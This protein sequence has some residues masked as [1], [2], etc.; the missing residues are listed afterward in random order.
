AS[1]AYVAEAT[2]ASAG[3][4]TIEVS[5]GS[6]A[7]GAYKLEAASFG[8]CSSVQALTLPFDGMVDLAPNQSRCFDVSLAADEVIRID[9][10]G[11]HNNVAG[12]VSLSTAL[13]VQ[14]IVA[15]VYQGSGPMV[16][17]VAV[18]GSYRLR[19]TNTSLNTGKLEMTITKPAVQGVLA[20][21]GTRTV[22]GLGPG[23][24]DQLFLLKPPA[25]GLYQVSLG[26]GNLQAGVRIDPAGTAFITGCACGSANVTTEARALRH[27]GPGLPVALVFH[28]A[29]SGDT[30][31]LSTGV[32]TLINRDVDID[33]APG[34]GLRVY[35]FDAHAGDVIAYR[36]A[37]PAAAADQATLSLKRPSGDTVPSAGAVTLPEDG[38][39][40]AMV[41]PS[42]GGAFGAHT[43]RINTAPPVQPLPLGAATTTVPFDLPLGQVLRYS[44]DLTQGE[45]V[46]LS[47]ATPGTLNVQASL[48]DPVVDGHVSTPGTGSGPFDVA[49]PPSFVR[50]SGSVILTVRGNTGVLERSR[51]NG[52][53]LRVHKPAP[54][55]AAIN[56]T[57]TGNLA[58]GAWTSYRYTVPASG[59]FLL[60][61]ASNAPAPYSLAATVWAASS[62]FSNYSGEFTSSAALSSYDFE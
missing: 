17:G 26:A 54:A 58:V 10:I 18:A 35:A 38:L 19:V 60:Y 21:P 20:V 4:Y 52:N 23:S 40:S 5:A 61:L 59:H 47:L 36:L 22:T 31:K 44:V 50:G 39:Y 25:D 2:V 33:G 12:S 6:N 32:P 55:T 62:V 24:A 48:A 9:P 43:L 30:V 29:G 27:T 15:G 37:Q 57:Q 34:S 13:G 8:N 7:P 14:Q 42:L 1:A 41:G 16:S 11:P 46:G 53:T 49:S 56:A 28:N 51:G 45:L 3:V